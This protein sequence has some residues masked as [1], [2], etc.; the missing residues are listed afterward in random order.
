MANNKLTQVQAI[1]VVLDAIKR[2]D[3]AIITDETIQKLFE[4]KKSLIRKNNKSTKALTE[5]RKTIYE[6]V[7]IFFLDTP[8]SLSDILEKN[9][10]ELKKVNIISPQGLLGAIKFGLD[11]NEIIRI[12]DKQKTLFSLNKEDSVNEKTE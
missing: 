11:N 7:K 10:E 2:K 6:K 8:T 9:R 1:T 12:K 3:F 5:K 4:I